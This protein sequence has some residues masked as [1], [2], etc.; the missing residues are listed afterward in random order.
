MQFCRGGGPL[1]IHRIVT[2]LLLINLVFIGCRN[3]EASPPSQVKQN[4]AS[5]IPED[6]ITPFIFTNQQLSAHVID[7]I[8]YTY[9]PYV[10]GMAQDGNQILLA[11]RKSSAVEF[12]LYT[13]NKLAW[14]AKSVF[15]NKNSVLWRMSYNASHSVGYDRIEKNDKQVKYWI[16]DFKS[17][18]KIKIG[19]FGRAVDQWDSHKELAASV[20]KM[21]EYKKL[22]GND[23]FD[24]SFPKS[25][26]GCDL[27]SK[28]R[29]GELILRVSE[30]KKFH[31]PI[32]KFLRSTSTEHWDDGYPWFTQDC[33]RSV[34]LLHDFKLDGV[35]VTYWPLV[36][37]KK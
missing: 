3:R 14:I 4:T 9:Y 19:V 7:S 35:Q 18:K 26:S 16:L 6:K 8:K 11:K 21:S 13:K 17:G 1:L 12:V 33:K 34:T 37:A 25:A 2:S 27:I 29:G 5:V 10:V 24:K 23:K 15:Q 30:E 22:F 20:E 31:L 28:V 32:N 36:L